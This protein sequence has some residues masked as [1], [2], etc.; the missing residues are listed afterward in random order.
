MEDHV[1]NKIPVKASYQTDVL[2]NGIPWNSHAVVFVIDETVHI[3]QVLP[4]H[5]PASLGKYHQSL[6][7][8]ASE[9]LPLQRRDK[10]TTVVHKPGVAGQQQ[11]L[12]WWGH[13]GLSG[14]GSGGRNKV[15][16][17]WGAWLIVDTNVDNSDLPLTWRNCYRLFPVLWKRYRQWGFH[18]SGRRSQQME[19]HWAQPQKP[20]QTH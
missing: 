4:P 15:W 9:L 8:T 6:L 16:W 1:I 10:V 5:S 17:L 19:G 14:G 18:P 7:L 20:C 3:E 2:W 12:P 11:W 13:R